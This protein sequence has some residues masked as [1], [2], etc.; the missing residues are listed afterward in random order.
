MN[1]RLFTRISSRS[2]SAASK[3]VSPVFSK[4]LS[5][6]R[7]LPVQSHAIYGKPLFHKLAG[8]TAFS[9]LVLAFGFYNSPAKVHL[10]S[11]KQP[12]SEKSYIVNV[13]D[14]DGNAFVKAPTNCPPFPKILR[15]SGQNTPFELFGVGV[16][17]VSFL[18]FHVYAIGLY[19]ASEDKETARKVLSSAKSGLADDDL[20][21]ALMDPE[22]G[23]DIISDLIDHN[24]RLNLRLVPVKKTDFGHLRDGFVRGVVGHAFYKKLAN[25]AEELQ[26]DPKHTKLMEEL[27]DGINELKLAFSRKKSV[28]KNNILNLVRG[29]DGSLEISY[30]RGT[31]ESD[32]TTK[33]MKL[34]TV[35]SPIISKIVFLRYLAGKEPASENARASSVHGLVSLV[36]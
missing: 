11:D 7:A 3:K 27:T 32:P 9:S 31:S 18:S 35:H 28:P 13:V 30:F 2:V 16:R 6:F 24:V 5:T 17:S 34:G 22:T 36:N 1:F 29:P 4:R 23:F 33:E 12:I 20:E 14:D 26:S 25:V 8:I 10:D 19:I 15:L 21:K